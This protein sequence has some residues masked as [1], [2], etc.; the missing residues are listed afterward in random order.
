MSA[1][2]ITRRPATAADLTIGAVVFKGNGATR[3]VVAG[4]YGNRGVTLAKESSAT[5]AAGNGLYFTREL[6]VE[7]L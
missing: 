6:T 3:W 4:D 7:V 5:R 1:S 2:Q